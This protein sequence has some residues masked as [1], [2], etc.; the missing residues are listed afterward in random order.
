M[1]DNYLW[2]CCGK[3]I[4]FPF[5]QCLTSVEVSL[6]KADY[7]YSELCLLKPHQNHWRLIIFAH[8][9]QSTHQTLNEPTEHQI[10]HY[11]FILHELNL[12]VFSKHGEKEKKTIIKIK[13]AL[14]LYI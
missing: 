14:M 9:G 13:I 2:N 4:N 12:F 7:Q 3:K 6:G 5:K 1:Q 8:S 10:L 11:L